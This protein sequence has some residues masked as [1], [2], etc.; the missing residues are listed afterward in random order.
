MNMTVC[1]ELEELIP[2]YVLGALEPTERSRVEKH[3]HDCPELRGQL[4]AYG[5]VAGQLAYAAPSVEPDRELKYRVLTAASPKRR[6]DFTFP[7][8]VGDML[9]SPVMVA[10]ALILAIGLGVWNIS[11]QAQ[12]SQQIA[13]DQKQIADSQKLIAQLGSE[14]DQ[15]WSVMA[16]GQGQPREL[17]GTEIAARSSG[18]L[19]GKG[20]QTS[21][22]LVVHNLP[23]LE[24]SKVYQLW[25]VDA[26][27]NR[28]SGGTFTLDSEGYGW[29][30][31]GLK[32]PLT[33]FT[34]M[35]I[36]IEPTGGSPAP[37]GPRV[38][39]TNL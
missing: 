6:F 19:Y 13:E 29:L 10:L 30:V 18:R 17:K 12:L 34:N 32:R 24:L 11:M 27:G 9:R 16:Y 26:S 20:D 31:V 3:L 21:F 36:T 23:P 5:Y 1:E 4:A 35:G 33:D 22:M 2:A 28:I 8:L 7:N 14:K 37:T 38:M 39:G 25:L 15:I